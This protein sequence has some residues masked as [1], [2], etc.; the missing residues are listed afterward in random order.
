[1]YTTPPVVES[2]THKQK[3]YKTW[4]FLIKLVKLMKNLHMIK[5]KTTQKK[6][7]QQR[8]NRKKLHMSSRI[9]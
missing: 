3:S 6:K 7:T 4:L 9:K 2:S 1:M 5:A 8:S